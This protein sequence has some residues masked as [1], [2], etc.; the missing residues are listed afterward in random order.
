MT[1]MINRRLLL[2]TSLAAGAAGAAQAAVTL[3]DPTSV[4]ATTAQLTALG[5]KNEAAFANDPIR[6]VTD[7]EWKARL[8]AGAYEVLR[9]DGTEIPGTSPLLNEHRAG[10]FVCLG[11]GLPLFDAKTKFESGTGWPSYYDFLPGSLGFKSDME[12]GYERVEYH[13]AKCLGH[14]GHRFSDGPKP[15]GLRYCTD[16]VALKFIPA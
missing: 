4:R 2:L 7:A 8:P 10:K 5:K 11:C 1:Q 6:K 13:C 12:L 16:G 15:T 14:L 9:R 3:V